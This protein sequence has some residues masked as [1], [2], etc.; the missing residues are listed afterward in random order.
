M[1]TADVIAYQD[2]HWRVGVFSILKQSG[3]VPTVGLRKGN[4]AINRCELGCCFTLTHVQTGRSACQEISVD[5]AKRLAGDL[6]RLDDWSKIKS[7]ATVKKKP[8]LKKAAK[9]ARKAQFDANAD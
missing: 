2:A 4:F 7:A 3:F 9:L 5:I 8:W 1:K 6:E